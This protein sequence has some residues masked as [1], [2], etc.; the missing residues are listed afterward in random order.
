MRATAKWECDRHRCSETNRQTNTK[1]YDIA[2]AALKAITLDAIEFQVDDEH[3]CKQNQW[4]HDEFLW[5]DEQS[6]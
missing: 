2:Q 4:E 5:N 6:A 3:H 1:T